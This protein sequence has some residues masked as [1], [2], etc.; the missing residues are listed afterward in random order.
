V[1]VKGR[2]IHGP[3]IGF[4]N[5]NELHEKLLAVVDVV[6]EDQV[7][8]ETGR[9]FA[10]TLIE[11]VQLEA[12]EW[13]IY[14][15]V[16]RGKKGKEFSRLD[17]DQYNDEEIGHLFNGLVHARQALLIPNYCIMDA[18]KIVSSKILRISQSICSSKKKSLVFCN[19][20]ANGTEYIAKELKKNGVRAE[21]YTGKLTDRTRIEVMREYR[22]GKTDVLCM[23]PVG[24]EGL[25][26]PE[27]EEIYIADLHFNPEVVRQMIGRSLRAGSRIKEIIVKIYLAHGPNGEKTVDNR[28]FDIF[29]RKERLISELRALIEG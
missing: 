20:V 7:I 1:Y 21:S 11:H 19:F 27:A 29:Q 3:V 10:T 8:S 17:L 2:P 4:K 16:T 26:V 24:G 28:I 13:K 23:S 15:K 6:S 25:D 22:E 18:E 12:D 5:K 9:P 14:K